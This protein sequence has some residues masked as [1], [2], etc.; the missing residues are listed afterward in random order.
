[1]YGLKLD[2]HPFFEVFFERI[3]TR[4][5]GSLDRFEVFVGEHGHI[6]I[7]DTP[8]P[9]TEATLGVNRGSSG[10]PAA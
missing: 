8:C 9:I 5:E 2:V 1:M 7:D 3:K 10:L 6:V 4:L